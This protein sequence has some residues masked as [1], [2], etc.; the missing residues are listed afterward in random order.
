MMQCKFKSQQSQSPYLFC[1]VWILAAGE[2][3]I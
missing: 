2:K 1:D 3:K